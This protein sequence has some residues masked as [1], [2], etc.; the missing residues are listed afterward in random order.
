[1]KIPELFEL[2]KRIVD[3]LIRSN[4]AHKKVIKEHLEKTRDKSDNIEILHI[5]DMFP[6][7]KQKGEQK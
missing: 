1:M 3:R 6:K 7:R 2:D 4:P 5:Q